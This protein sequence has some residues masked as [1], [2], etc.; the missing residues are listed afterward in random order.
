VEQVQVVDLM[1]EDRE[2]QGRQ[3]T[4]SQKQVIH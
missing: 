3:D 1:Q 2:V 4:M